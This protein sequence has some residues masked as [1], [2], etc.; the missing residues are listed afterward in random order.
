MSPLMRLPL[1]LMALAASALRPSTS[2]LGYD[3]SRVVEDDL[4]AL[5]PLSRDVLAGGLDH[6]VCALEGVVVG[7]E[8]LK[9]H[10]RAAVS[11]G[12]DEVFVGLLQHVPRHGFPEDLYALGDAS[13]P[14]CLPMPLG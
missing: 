13:L 7:G 2:S 9:G 5:P 4:E 12:K 11:K 1:M 6:E 10:V 14:Q 3:L 8:E